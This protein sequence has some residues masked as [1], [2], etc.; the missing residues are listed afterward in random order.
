MLVLVQLK[1]MLSETCDR[2]QHES[3]EAASIPFLAEFPDFV[4][5]N[6]KFVLRKKRWP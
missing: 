6:K 1:V 5:D 2:A 4:T 3:G